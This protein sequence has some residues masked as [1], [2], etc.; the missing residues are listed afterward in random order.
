MSY[1]IVYWTFSPLL[2]LLLIIT[3]PKITEQMQKN[4]CQRSLYKL[5]LYVHYTNVCVYVIPAHCSNEDDWL[6]FGE[7]LFD[8]L[9]ITTGIPVILAVIRPQMKSRHFFFSCIT[10]L[11]TWKFVKRGVTLLGMLPYILIKKCINPTDIL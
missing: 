6:E 10:I 1:C 11:L 3:N 2:P 5:L 9:I 4:E 8:L 7:F